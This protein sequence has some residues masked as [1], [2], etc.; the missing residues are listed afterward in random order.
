[1]IESSNN[2]DKESLLSQRERM[3]K[4]AEWEGEY[5]SGLDVETRIKQTDE[6]LKFAYETMPKEKIEE[7]QQASLNNKIELQKRL[8]LIFKK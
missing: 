2:F 6:M 1:M 3:K 8:N 7:I 5:I 4:Y